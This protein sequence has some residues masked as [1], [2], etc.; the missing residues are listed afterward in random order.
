MLTEEQGE[1][2]KQEHPK[3]DF[4]A[5]FDLDRKKITRTFVDRMEQAMREADAARDDLKEV[6]AEAREA[7]FGPRDIEAMKKIA[8]LRKDDKGGAAREQLESLKKIGGAVGF[9]LFDWAEAQ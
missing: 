5:I 3:R 7:N 6:V 1:P 4:N 9:D 2:G 8:K